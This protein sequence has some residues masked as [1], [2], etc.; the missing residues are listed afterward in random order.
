MRKVEDYEWE[1][2]HYRNK[3]GEEVF[4]SI[5]MNDYYICRT[6]VE[7]IPEKILNI[8]KHINVDI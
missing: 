1:I 8:A 4:S 6:K 3:N 5:F 2:I 7:S